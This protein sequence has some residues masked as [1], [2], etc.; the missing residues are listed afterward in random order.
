MTDLA[1]SQVIE[2]RELK[3]R[4]IELRMQQDKVP[5]KHNNF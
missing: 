5:R 4:K 1:C 3:D 2:F